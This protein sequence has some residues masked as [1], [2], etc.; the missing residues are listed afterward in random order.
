MSYGTYDNDN[1]GTMFAAD[2]A[3]TE[4]G[5]FIRRVYGHVFAAI[6]AFIGIEAALLNMPGIDETFARVFSFRWAPLVL[7]V[8]FMGAGWLARMWAHGSTSPAMQYTG[9]SLYVIA[10][11]VFFAPI[12]YVAN[13]FV[14][15][16]VITTAGFL[17]LVIF[18]GLTAIV[19]VTGANFSFLGTGLM[20]AGWAAL[21][22][23]L[24]GALFGFSLG[25]WFSVAMVV[26]ASGYILYDTSEILHTYRTNQYVGAALELFASVAI[27]FYYILRIAMSLKSND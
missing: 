26:L 23:A 17:T 15:G 24:C 12:L 13:K 6:L 8:L 3:A 16:D 1:Y 2:A 14:G 19:F 22:I 27:L 5:T 9:L 21:A 7:M 20:F 10:Q 18:A 11:A 4:R 25:M